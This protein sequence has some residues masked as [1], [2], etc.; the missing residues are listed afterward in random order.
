MR[1][2]IDYSLAVIEGVSYETCIYSQWSDAQKHK[3]QRWNHWFW[4]TLTFPISSLC[5]CMA[6]PSNPIFMFC[7]V[8]F[9]II[10]YWTHWN[11]VRYT[12]WINYKIVA[13]YYP[14]YLYLLKSHKL[15]H[16]QLAI[17]DVIN[18][19][20]GDKLNIAYVYDN[21]PNDLRTLKNLKSQCDERI[22]RIHPIKKMIDE[23][24]LFWIIGVSLI[25]SLLSD[26]IID[27]RLIV[28]A[29]VV[30]ICQLADRLLGKQLIF[31]SNPVKTLSRMLDALLKS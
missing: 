15:R 17:Y 13:K 8:I 25:L 16:L 27:D 9:A 21:W 26:L 23:Y 5:L 14:Q 6:F 29:I 19:I 30:M 2:M 3:K 22:K 7:Y 12:N 24:P 11:G 31:K 18:H 4:I 28:V 1:Y 10:L 20:G